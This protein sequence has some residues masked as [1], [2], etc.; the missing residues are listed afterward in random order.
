MSD[1][2][3]EESSPQQQPIVEQPRW[4]IEAEEFLDSHMRKITAD[5]QRN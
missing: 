4:I 2:D 3:K 5:E 1:I